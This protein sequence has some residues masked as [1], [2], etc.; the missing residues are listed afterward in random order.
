MTTPYELST[1]SFVGSY[2]VTPQTNMSAGQL[3]DFWIDKDTGTTL[4]CVS[5][6]RALVGGFTLGTA[7]NITTTSRPGTTNTFLF[8]ASQTSGIPSFFWWPQGT[9]AGYTVLIGNYTLG[10]LYKYELSVPWDTTTT[11]Y[12]GVNNTFAVAGGS[13]TG[14]DRLLPYN[15][16]VFQDYDDSTGPYIGIGLSSSVNGDTLYYAPFGTLITS[17]DIPPKLT[18]V[19][20]PSGVAAGSTTWYMDQRYVLADKLLPRNLGQLETAGLDVV[21]SGTRIYVLEGTNQRVWSYRTYNPGGAWNNVT[22]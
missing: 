9:R 11:T 10:N 3:R 4:V 14:A 20:Y 22:V 13:Y 18:R 2:T 6:A 7:W 16:V 21:Q 15:G 19:S 17:S 8:T 1:A 12:I 5:S